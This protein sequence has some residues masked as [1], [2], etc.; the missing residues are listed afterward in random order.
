MFILRE[1]VSFYSTATIGDK[2]FPKVY[3]NTITNISDQANSFKTIIAENISKDYEILCILIAVSGY[4]WGRNI[5]WLF[6][7]IVKCFHN[8]VIF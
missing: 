3:I 6:A 1:C 8:K 4:S 5:Y 2:I 7:Y